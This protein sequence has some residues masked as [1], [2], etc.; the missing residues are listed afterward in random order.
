MFVGGKLQ[1]CHKVTLFAPAIRPNLVAPRETCT[2]KVRPI[3]VLGELISAIWDMQY[4]W[5]QQPLR[6]TTQHIQ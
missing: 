1:F 2:A 3:L 4:E 5:T 6:N